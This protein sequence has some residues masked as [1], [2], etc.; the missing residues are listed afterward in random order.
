MLKRFVC[1]LLAVATALMMMSVASAD[2]AKVI[3][4][5]ILQFAEHGSLDNCRNGFIEGLA[6]AGYVE[7]ENVEFIYQNAQTDTGNAA[8]IAAQFA[9]T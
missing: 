6:E 2:E 5:G 7:G 9:E 4:I 1:V 3:K 8:L